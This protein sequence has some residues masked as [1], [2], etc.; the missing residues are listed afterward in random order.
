LT[1]VLLLLQIAVILA[2]C[3]LLHEVVERIGQ[4]PVIGEIIAGL[5]LGPSFFGWLAPNLFARLFPPASLPALNALSQIGL[6]LFMF[7]VG[8]HLDVAEVWALR[9]VAGLAGLLSIAVPFAA[10]LALARPLHILAPDSPMLPFSLFIAVAMSITAFPV[11]ARILADQKLTATKLGH[12]AIACAA[13][14]DVIAWSL[15]AWI[16]AV[17]RSAESSLAKPIAIVLIYSAV[18]WFVVRPL[19]RWVPNELATMLIFVF[20]SSWATELAGLH[21]LFGAFFAGVIWP[22]GSVN[23]EEVSAKIEPIAMAV[24]I[25]LFFSYTGL[26]TNISAVNWAYTLIIIAVAVFGKIGG[27]FAGARMMGFDSR[28][29]LSLG[30]LLNT[31]GLVEL[32]V[33]NVGLDLGILTPALFSMMVVMALVTTLMTTP[34]LNV[35]KLPKIPR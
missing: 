35:L 19:L 20:L 13:F 1:L 7:L 15:L 32:V 14:N 9:G 12:V 22:R 21:A 27:A 30:V 8:L 28:N 26:R 17:S 24:L 6:V 2:V 11:L 25:P 4:P 29:A 16:V 18:M 33:L 5:L 3:R 10:G 23:F 34:A 31:R